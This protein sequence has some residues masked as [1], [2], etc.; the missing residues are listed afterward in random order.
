M[1]RLGDLWR[2][3]QETIGLTDHSFEGVMRGR[4]G[5]W[6]ALAEGPLD[7]MGDP[8]PDVTGTGPTPEQ[9]LEALLAAFAAR[10]RRWRAAREAREVATRALGLRGRR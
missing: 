3:A 7:L 6:L 10:R 9:A 1:R 8:T 2:E 4:D 5:G